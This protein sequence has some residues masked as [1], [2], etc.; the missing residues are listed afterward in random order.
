MTEMERYN[1]WTEIA[2]SLE[3]LI[4]TIEKEIGS[5]NFTETSDRHGLSKINKK[6]YEALDVA[7]KAI[8]KAET[9]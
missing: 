7:Q 8:Q 9:E 1:K 5:K 3:A 2:E 4:G 6:L